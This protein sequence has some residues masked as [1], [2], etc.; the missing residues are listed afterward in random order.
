MRDAY[1]LTYRVCC[2]LLLLTGGACRQEVPAPLES[3]TRQGAVGIDSP[4]KSVAAASSRLI[5]EMWDGYAMRDA[6]NG[7]STRIGHAQT[8]VHEVQENGQTLHRTTSVVHTAMQRAGQDISQDMTLTSWDSQDGSL[9]RFE[10]RVSGAGGEIV[11]VG[12]VKDGKLNID[13][14]TLGRTQ[15]QAIAWPVDAGGLF[16]A[17]QSLR[18]RPMQPGEER[19]VR[20]LMPLMNLPVTS[21]LKA[22]QW[23]EVES[24]QA[25][26]KRRESLLR[27]DVMMKMN[28]G[29][30]QLE[31]VLW[32]DSRGA[33]VKTLVPSIGQES[34]RMSKEEALRQTAEQPYDLLIASTVPVKGNVEGLGARQQVTYRARL[35]NGAIRGLFSEGATQQVKLLDENTAEIVVTAMRPG[36]AGDN[37]REGKGAVNPEP[38]D[39]TSNN[40]IQVD[41]P[42]IQKMAAEVTGGEGEAG[43]I[44]QKLE[45]LVAES[46]E[47]K[48]Y[49]QA[50]ATAAEVARSGEGDC[51]EHAVLLAALCR[52]KQIPA[53]C[54]FGLVYYPPEKGFAYHMWNEALIDG[55]WVPLDATLGQ[56]GI[57]ADHIKLGDSN[58]AGGSP[59]ADLLAVMQVFG[60]LELEVVEPR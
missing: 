50:F 40:F 47:N 26:G 33:V 56:G 27:I 21:T 25:S 58:L 60:R 49:T 48:S 29:A 23:E 54:A 36:T 57:A 13:T 15:S 43:N 39:L 14:T 10:T 34:V 4:A 42:L 8:T 24:P 35:K 18:R 7:K 37:A 41:D 11:S 44:A 5:E 22:K 20:G 31:S 45:K 3:S 6:A 1:A 28:L 9:V 51:T 32:M 55:T 2:C 59:L 38:A 17:E 52:A 16:A 46:V 12:A 30:Q 53:R 19:A